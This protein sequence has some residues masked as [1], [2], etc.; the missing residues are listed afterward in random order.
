M[1][2]SGTIY[3]SVASFLYI[4]VILI[5]YLFKER[6]N[7][8]ETRLFTRLLIVSFVSLVAELYIT[9]IPINMEIPL[10][11]FSLKFY[12]ILCVLWLSYFMEYVFIITRNHEDRSLINYKQKYKKVYTIFWIIVLLFTFVIFLLPINFYNENGMKYSYGLGVDLVFTLSG[13]YTIV[14]LFYVIKNIKK[15]KNSG[16]MPIIFL[17]ILMGIVGIIQKT[18]PSLLLANTCFALITSLMYHT[19]ENP[20]TKMVDELVKNREIIERNGEEKSLFL[21]KMTQELKQPIEQISKNI[22]KYNSSSTS[23]DETEKIFDNIEMNNNKLKYMITDVLGITSFDNRNIKIMNSSYNLKFLLKEIEKRVKDKIPNNIDFKLDYS[24]DLPDDL[25]GDS[26]KLKQV[27]MT[28]INNSIEHTLNGYIHIDV[29]SITKYD[30]C[31]IVITVKDSGSGIELAKVNKILES[32]KELSEKD[33]DKLTELDVDLKVAAK[34]IKLLNGTFYIKSEINNG[35]EV[36]ITIDQQIV[37]E[38]NSNKKIIDN[39]IYSRTKKRKVLIVNDSDKEIKVIKKI[40]SGLG[41]EAYSSIHGLD[42][43][44]RIKHNET[45]DYILIDDEMEIMNGIK[46]VEE[47]KKLNVEGKKLV[48]LNK[49]KI[50]IGHHYIKEGF[51]E[52]I[53]KSK[54]EEELKNKLI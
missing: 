10:F 45:F 35:T 41:Y 28:I 18:N 17:I 5:V 1:G 46:L 6:V 19:I 54:I 27:L 21:F 3:L 31:R 43:I 25:Y 47:M 26:I 40:V 4:L 30:L 2:S 24:V 39:Y 12:L 38:K 36:I 50:F 7:T 11:V 33:Y 14:M 51:D 16:Y 37:E 22:K 20:D 53:D 23:K 29:S 13:I 15:I 34:I 52:F 44:D 8:S 48:L 32:Q 49:D 42:C 9:I